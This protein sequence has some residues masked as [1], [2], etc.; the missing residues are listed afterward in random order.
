[1]PNNK[2]FCF[3]NY[4]VSGFN[5]SAYEKV[6]ELC[7]S[8]EKK[9]KPKALLITG[10][11]G[12][13]K[14]HLLRA[15]ENKFKKADANVKVSCKKLHRFAQ[16]IRS[17]NSTKAIMKKYSNVDIFLLDHAENISEEKDI[18]KNLASILDTMY[19]KNIKVVLA[20]MQKFDKMKGIILPLKEFFAS[21]EIIE[22]K[23]PDL[24]TREK[25]ARIKA[26]EENLD[27]PEKVIKFI[28]RKYPKN[29]RKIEAAV[30]GIMAFTTLTDGKI[31]LKNIKKI[32][33]RK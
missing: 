11:P 30:I 25:I 32:L 9:N 19:N 8:K 33:K 7:E 13:G 22:I 10:P 3:D 4:V 23:Y 17:C 26:K 28:A 27:I 2:I 6:K 31:T 1:M 29:I 14:T 20:S 16:E 5:K 21:K 18:Q 15:V 24:K 12:N